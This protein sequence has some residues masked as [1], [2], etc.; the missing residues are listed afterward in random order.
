MRIARTIT[1]ARAAV[2]ELRGKSR[3]VGL[4]PTMGALHA[5]HLSL[6]RAARSACDAVVATI[7]VNPTQFAPNEDFSKYPRTF[8]ADCALLESEG[9]DVL[10][11]PEPA[12]IYPEGFSTVVEV[13]GISDRLDGESRPG[14]F[15]GVATVVAKLFNIVAPDKAFFGQKDAAQVA[16]LRRMVRDLNFSPEIVVCPIVRDP[17]GLALSSRNR[18]LSPEDR[19]HALVLSRT[20]HR[21]D[22]RIA[23][24]ISDSASLLDAGRA[25]LAEEPAVRLDYLRIV[26]PDTLQDLPDVRH[27]ALVAVAAWVGP[28]RLID[29][30]LIPPGA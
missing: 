13:E 21:I 11:A 6:V 30:V 12:E 27:G 25:V 28:A 22:E 24:G 17:D 23:A 29:N 9:V 20:L 19:R 7:F 4:V 16:I 2:A 5:G 3:C 26:D 1:E 18:Y 15:R 10:F 14:H 8:D